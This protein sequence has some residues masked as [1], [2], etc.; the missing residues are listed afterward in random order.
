MESIEL[1]K[2]NGSSTGIAIASIRL[3]TLDNLLK[4]VAHFGRR[5]RGAEDVAAILTGQAVEQ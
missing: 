3:D 4:D 1:H 2:R 5:E